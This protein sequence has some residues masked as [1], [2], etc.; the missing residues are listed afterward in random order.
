MIAPAMMGQLPCTP[1]QLKEAIQKLGFADVY[2]VAQGADV[3]TKLKRQ[4]LRKDLNMVQ[5]L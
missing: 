5:N 1:K 2:E 3:T 4:N